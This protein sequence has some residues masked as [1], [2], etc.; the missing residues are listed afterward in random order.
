MNLLNDFIAT[1]SENS[2][3]MECL[4]WCKTGICRWSDYSAH[5][6]W[7]VM[8]MSYKLN[9]RQN[10]VRG[11]YANLS[12]VG[13][14]TLQSVRMLTAVSFQTLSRW[15]L[16]LSN[17]YNFYAFTSKKFNAFWVKNNYA[18]RWCNTLNT[19]LLL[20]HTFVN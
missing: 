11:V 3:T 6:N 10:V 17:F 15:V 9:R 20:Q 8:L 18:T 7:A 14:S 4:L 5:N 19:H 16:L 2:E 13:C 12:S 1:T